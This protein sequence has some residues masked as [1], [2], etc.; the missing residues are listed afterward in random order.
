M[1]LQEQP[2]VGAANRLPDARTLNDHPRPTNGRYGVGGRFETTA[3]KMHV[4]L[5]LRTHK[6]INLQHGRS[7]GP[8]PH[9]PYMC[10]QHRESETQ[11]RRE[12]REIHGLTEKE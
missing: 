10:C 7:V 3:P 12:L 8:A 4:R 6:E 1:P 9:I 11:M 5:G 2:R